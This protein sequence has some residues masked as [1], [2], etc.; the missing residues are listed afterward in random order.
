L[1]KPEK[2]RKSDTEV[3]QGIPYYLKREF[4]RADI[5]NGRPTSSGSPRFTGRIKRGGVG[6]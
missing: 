3:I 6:S 2:K 1:E 5:G 4:C